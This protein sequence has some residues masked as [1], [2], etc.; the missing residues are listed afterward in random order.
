MRAD[1]RELRREVRQHCPSSAAKLPEQRRFFRAR[2]PVP[3][4]AQRALSHSVCI[5]GIVT[6]T[7]ACGRI[8]LNETVSRQTTFWRS[9]ADLAGFEAARAV[10]ISR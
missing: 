5:L 7:G 3:L 4:S 2:L 9:A 8:E 1:L 10:L 6:V